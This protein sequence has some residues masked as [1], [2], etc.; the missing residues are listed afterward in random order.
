MNRRHW[1]LI[2]VFAINLFQES[3]MAWREAAP[4]QTHHT[5]HFSSQAFMPRLSS[6]KNK[7]S[8]RTPV[9]V[10]LIASFLVA[11]NFSQIGQVPQRVYESIFLIIFLPIIT[12]FVE[13]FS[14][15]GIYKSRLWRGMKFTILILYLGA[16]LRIWSLATV[17]FYAF[18]MVF[19]I[20]LESFYPNPSESSSGP[21]L[22]ALIHSLSE[23]SKSDKLLQVALKGVKGFQRE[24]NFGLVNSG[25]KDY[26]NRT[27]LFQSR[28]ARFPFFMNY[29]LA[30][31][32]LGFYFDDWFLSIIKTNPQ[33]EATSD[34]LKKVQ[35][36]A[37]GLMGHAL[38]EIF[39]SFE[40]IKRLWMYPL[41]T[42]YL[43]WQTI[44]TTLIK[45][46]AASYFYPLISSSGASVIKKLIIQLFFS[47]SL[48]PP[49]F[50]LH[51]PEEYLLHKTTEHAA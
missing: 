10:L 12:D 7:L 9:I 28:M 43:L 19:L 26:K 22:D 36:S 45:V 33:S 42:P 46:I 17:M 30:R 21:D 3:A 48:S 6:F 14:S 49:Y 41:L 23:A 24:E 31:R 8:G 35:D 2:V 38:W 50:T 1:A 4:T 44:A 27:I 5:Q 40:T 18:M 16:H 47:P 51:S 32:S 11:K 34:A 13:R 37:L 39:A 25:G 15:E 29:L 20:A